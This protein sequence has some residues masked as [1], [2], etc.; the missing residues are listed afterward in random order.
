[1][2]RNVTISSN[3]APGATSI[4]ATPKPRMSSCR[5]YRSGGTPA[6][7][8][9]RKSRPAI[10]PRHACQPRPQPPPTR[11]QSEPACAPELWNANR[12]SSSALSTSSSCAPR[13]QTRSRA[14]R[15]QTPAVA[16]RSRAL[17][18]PRSPPPGRAW[19]DGDPAAPHTA[20][21]AL[22]P[23]PAAS[24]PSPREPRR[25]AHP[26]CQSVSSTHGSPKFIHPLPS[27]TFADLNSLGRSSQSRPSRFPR[28]SP[29]RLSQS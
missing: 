29:L 14:P 6:R 28:R 3:Y 18:C 11:P 2:P 1:M 17:R 20:R 25:V 24:N 16:P 22:C 8:R 19:H 12:S 26:P 27:M 4:S 9:A 21:T 10:P 23:T 13:S 5:L 15:P 7:A